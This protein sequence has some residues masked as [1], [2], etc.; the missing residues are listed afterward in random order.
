MPRWKSLEIDEMLD[1]IAAEA[2]IK[3]K[4]LLK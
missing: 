2:F 4:K 3:N 1:L